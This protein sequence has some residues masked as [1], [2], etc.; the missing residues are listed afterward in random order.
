MSTATKKRS[1]PDEEPDS[2]S[3]PPKKRG[4]PP[5]EKPA[6]VSES[7]DEKKPVSKAPAATKGRKSTGQA[8]TSK[9]SRD[10]DAMDEDGTEFGSM[11]KWLDSTS[12]EHLVDHIDTVEKNTDGTLWVYFQLYVD[13]GLLLWNAHFMHGLP[14]SERHGSKM[15][16]E[17]ASL[18]RKKMPNLVRLLT[19]LRTRSPSD[20]AFISSWTSTKTTSAGGHSSP[21][22]MCHACATGPFAEG[23]MQPEKRGV[24]YV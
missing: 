21:E 12:W 9:K 24:G 13:N 17:D 16:R 7:E 2:A 18:C 4:R 11:K 1:S 3:A 8:S 19:V 5:K 22:G 15:C 6:V 20:C 14:R 10:A 23:R